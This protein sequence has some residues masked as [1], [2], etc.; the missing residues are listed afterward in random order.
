M[1]LA[2]SCLLVVWVTSISSHAAAQQSG[3]RLG[4][5]DFRASPGRPIGWRGD[6]TGCY[7]AADGPT[8]WQRRLDSSLALVHCQADRPAD[9]SSPTGPALHRVMSGQWAGHWQIT[10]WLVLAPIAPPADIRDA[11]DDEV[12]PAEGTWTAAAGEQL[13]G[14][15][16]QAV[17]GQ[18]IDVGEI[19]G[20]D[21]EGQVAYLASYL[22]A[23]AAFE[24]GIRAR[25]SED[26]FR[27][28]VWI[29]G[30]P[31]STWEHSHNK[32]QQGW[33]SI[34]FKVAHA[35]QYKNWE[36]W[37]GLFPFS[38]DLQYQCESIAWTTKIPGWGF[39]MP[40][41]VGQ[42]IYATSEPNDLICLDKQSGKVEWL[43][44]HPVWAVLNEQERAELPKSQELQKKFA[45][46]E[47][48]NAR[49]PA[50]WTQQEQEEHERIANDLTND[51]QA[52]NGTYRIG[53]VGAAATLP[54]PP[55]PTDSR[56]MCGSGK[57]ACWPATTCRA[58]ATTCT[59]C[60]L[61]RGSTASTLRP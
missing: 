37:A 49:D 58:I 57:P 51:V 4:S 16:W 34:V 36:F 59:L 43:R 19:A 39:G 26:H 29:N 48:L 22:Y 17:T 42:H 41:I 61:E 10:R 55:F 18:M 5:P 21:Q 24:A 1:T 14:R 35:R 2:R 40:I 9:Q 53:K 45:R 11:I 15:Q 60:R 44:S 54:P 12:L 56:F 52:G 38:E 27:F 7:P 46:L 13:G 47:E 31:A 30:K 6:S 50:T 8:H 28:K 32:F 3:T 33:N 25:R 20:A 23:P